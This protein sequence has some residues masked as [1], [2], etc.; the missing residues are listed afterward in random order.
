MGGK[1]VLALTL[2][3]AKPRWHTLRKGIVNLSEP[4]T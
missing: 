2:N 4:S 1:G 3:P